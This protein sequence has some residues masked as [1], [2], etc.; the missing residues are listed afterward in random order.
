MTLYINKAS[1]KPNHIYSLYEG[2][3]I[4][5][6]GTSLMPDRKGNMSKYLVYIKPETLV[7]Y[8]DQEPL[9]SILSK[10]RP[11][12]FVSKSPRR[13]LMFDIGTLE[14]GVLKG[15]VEDFNFL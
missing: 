4:I 12:L 10:E 5:F 6:L 3:E 15:E 11:N 9:E 8:P 2:G 14:K 13:G 7:N 1:L